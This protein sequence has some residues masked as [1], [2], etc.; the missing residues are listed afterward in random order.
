M[1]ARAPHGQRQR[2]GRREQ[3]CVNRSRRSRR[4]GV[5]DDRG[6]IEM[7][8]V[9]A[10]MHL[11]NLDQVRYPWLET[12]AD[13]WFI[14]PYG[15]I[16]KSHSL[17]D[18]LGGT[19][20]IEV[21]KTVHI[22]NGSA[23]SHWLAESRWVQSIAD[24]PRSGGRPNAIVA[25][26]DLSRPNAEELLR[27]QAEI[28][29]VRGVRQILNVHPDPYYAF[30]GRDFMREE[31]WRA[32]FARLARFGLSFDLQI[33]PSQMLQA[34]L[35]A[36][37]HP[38][39]LIILNHTGMFVDRHST[40]GWRT[41]RDGMRELASQE[42]VAVKISGMGMIDH[43]WTV[44]SIRPYVLETIDCFGVER[45][46]FASNFPVDGLYGTY[47]GLW[48]AYED[49]VSGMS[50]WEKERLFRSNAERFYRM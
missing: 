2:A 17:D 24:N 31:G 8:V 34:A 47:S 46:M 6:E 32:G 9:D 50:S 41:W 38:D 39:T 44:E 42:N 48:Q 12:P 43:Q 11:C 28:P 25:G 40:S 36:A 30:A 49:C 3:L 27:R 37:D 7:K 14:G 33:Y 4:S 21:V 23:E 1:A 19:G 20:D 29:G 22:E 26:I 45:S 16:A 13:N 18:F 10:H 15:S 35:L 5:I